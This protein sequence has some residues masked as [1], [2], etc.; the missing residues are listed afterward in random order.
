LEPSH[1]IV[2]VDAHFR[3]RLKKRL[4][5]ITGVHVVGESSDSE[6]TTAMI[7]NRK[8]DIAILN[9]SLRD[10][11]GIEALRHIKRLMVPPIMIIVT[12]DPS[13]GDKTARTLAGPNSFSTKQR[14]I[15][16]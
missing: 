13:R 2:L 10:G 9:S 7:L 8:P 12:D 4:E 6:E 11:R 15:I 3:D 1:D 5:K 16:K 14:K